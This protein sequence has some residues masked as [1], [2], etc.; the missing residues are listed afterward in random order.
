MNFRVGTGFDVHS[1][2]AGNGVYL[3]GF[4]IESDIS[5]KGHSDADVLIHAIVDALLGS[6]ALGD[7]GEHFPDS[8]EKNKG[9]QSKD[10]LEYAV[11][12]IRRKGYDIANID[13]V[14]IGEKPKILPRRQEI[15]NRLA[16]IMKLEKNQVSVKA[17]TTEKLGFTG[18]GEGL[19]AQVA[20][21]IYKR[22]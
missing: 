20:A 15:V 22:A 6:L 8:D 5:L 12:L 7:I 18:R 1:I 16:E 21:L 4:F 2:E 10:F 19:A 9:R 11:T 3:G 14:I 13:A 17:T